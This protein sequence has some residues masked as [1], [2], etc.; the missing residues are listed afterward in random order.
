MVLIKVNKLLHFT[1]E[2]CGPC[3]K[4]KPIV[5]KFVEDYKLDYEQIDVDSDFKKAQEFNV[6][7][8]PTFISFK[9]G[10]YY[11]R[12]TGVPSEFILKGM[13]SI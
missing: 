2:W 5:D 9:D 12:H 7:S 1:A 8:I 13:F 6:L 10:E 11:D 4:A 3:K